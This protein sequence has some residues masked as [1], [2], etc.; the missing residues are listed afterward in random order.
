VIAA[1]ALW[2]ARGYV[3]LIEGRMER[4]RAEQAHLLASLRK[5]LLIL[6]SKEEPL[7]LSEREEHP[8][9]QGRVERLSQE[10]LQLSQE[11]AQVTEELERERVKRQEAQQRVSQ[12][13]Q[14]RELERRAHRD[15][16]RRIDRLNRELK[17]IV[18]K[19]EEGA[20]DGQ[21]KPQTPLPVLKEFSKE[22]PTTAPREL[23]EKPLATQ[24][25]SQEAE[26]PP[27]PITPLKKRPAS[28]PKEVWPEEERPEERPRLGRWIPHPDDAPDKGTSPKLK[29][30]QRSDDPVEMFR[31]HY[32]KYLDNYEGYLEL[33]GML[34]RIREGGETKQPA[35][36]AEREW[37]NRLR[38]AN[39]GI[40]RTSVRLDTLE[41]YNPELATDDRVSRRA[42][43][44]RRHS[45]L[46]QSGQGRTRP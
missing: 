5:E 31:R 25:A 38:R 4:L 41:E 20:K 11:K 8:N 13:R 23:V 35:S 42:G 18:P 17:E 28:E 24:R 7:S 26:K 6:R 15:A 32:D 34:Y 27:R 14:G 22:P 2:N 45:E 10:C 12:E 1:L 16:E 39:D 29:R 37:E 33:I 30:S 40:K 21:V 46:Q 3:E 9:S 43:L 19:E 36:F 44:A